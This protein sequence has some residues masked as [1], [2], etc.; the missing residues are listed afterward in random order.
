MKISML[1]FCVV[2]LCEHAGSYR[3][4]G[5]TE[6]LHLQGRSEALGEW[7]LYIGITE[8]QGWRTILRAHAQ[9]DD[10]FR[11][12]SFVC[13]QEFCAAKWGLEILHHYY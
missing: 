7:I 8:G 4:L 2:T 1:V 10:T 9:I 3:R 6:H 11:R 13:P 12:N 5:G